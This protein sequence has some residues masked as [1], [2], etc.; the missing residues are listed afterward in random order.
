MGQHSNHYLPR[1]Y[2]GNGKN[3]TRNSHAKRHIDFSITTCGFCDQPQ[4]ISP[5]PC[6]TNKS[7]WA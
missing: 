2:V 7:F 4:K 1:W 6:E 3:V 5:S